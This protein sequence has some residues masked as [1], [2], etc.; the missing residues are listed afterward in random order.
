MFGCTLFEG[1]CKNVMRLSYTCNVVYH[2]MTCTDIIDTPLM[3]M[4]VVIKGH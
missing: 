1:V 4:T 3:F 2:V